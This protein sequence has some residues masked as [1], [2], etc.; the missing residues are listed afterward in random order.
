MTFCDGTRLDVTEVRRVFLPVGPDQLGGAQC[1]LAGD[2]LTHEHFSTAAEATG[3]LFELAHDARACR[4]DHRG[5]EP[6]QFI[7]ELLGPVPRP[8]RL[9]DVSEDRGCGPVESAGFM[10]DR[11]E[12]VVDQT[13][14]VLQV[15]KGAS[16]VGN[17][18]SVVG[19]RQEKNMKCM[20]KQAFSCGRPRA[21]LVGSGP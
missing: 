18:G 20:E 9:A 15:G 1:L 19:H 6:S 5:G 16:E 17:G 10:V 3:D 21:Q 7:T 4:G 8:V 2:G 14:P 11:V 12:R 13:N